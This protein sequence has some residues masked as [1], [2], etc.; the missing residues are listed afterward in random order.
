MIQHNVE[1]TAAYARYLKENPAETCL[2]FKELLINVTNFFRD[3]KAFAVLKE[4]IL[5]SLL[6][7]KLDNYVFRAWVPGCATGEEAYSIAIL[8]HEVM[9]DIHQVFKVQIYGTDLT[10]DAISI[11]RTGIYPPNIAQ[12]ATPERLQRFFVKE[13]GKYRVKKDIREMVVFAVQNVIKDPPFTKLDLLSCRNLMIYLEP[14]VQ[15]RMMRSFHYALKPDGVLFLSPSES[16]GNHTDLFAPL[17]SKWKCY[18]AVHSLAAARALVAQCLSWATDGDIK[19]A[20]E[21]L[22]KPKECNL[23]DLTQKVLL[24]YFAPAAVVTDGKGSVLYVHGDTGKYLR[25]APG[26]A[27]LNIVK[28]A[29]EGL[30]LELRNAIHTAGHEDMPTLNREVQVKTNGGFSTVSLSVRLLPGKANGEHLL[31]ISFQD[32][33]RPLAKTARKRTAKPAELG[34]IEE[35]E[36]DLA[37]LKENNQAIIEEQQAS[38]EE[39]VTVNSELQGK[40][41]QLADMQNDMKNLL[42]NVNIGIIFL[43]RHLKIRSFTRDAVRVYRLVAADV[44]RPLGD[45]RPIVPDVD[46]LPTAQTVLETLI[47][48]EHELD[49]GGTWLLARI[50][51]YP[52]LEN[53]IDGVV[54]TFTD[55]TVRIQAIATQ[56]ALL[57]AESIVKTIRELFV[58]LDCDLK[59]VSA[60]DRF[61]QAFCLAPDETQ[62]QLIYGL[63][64]GA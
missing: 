18:R 56:E 4:E 59:V 60:S 46:L 51:P 58:V 54:L 57:I 39:L 27:S 32:A 13:D 37:Y 15:N 8:L 43:D 21:T 7:G 22:T 3:A 41:E 14:E 48:Y 5:P 16:I 31:L 10:D 26:Q 52:T 61:Y 38:N 2:L 40:I 53:M 28:L 30:E 35:L 62:G 11:A 44:G 9:D 55:I 64:N 6:K 45:I 29:R 36:R 17:N 47:P 19:T 25:P 63:G 34:H 23:G 20:K 24:Q 49:M 1:D 42:D 50:Q 33:N 12:H